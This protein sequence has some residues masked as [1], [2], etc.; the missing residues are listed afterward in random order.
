VLYILLWAAI[1]DANGGDGGGGEG[2]GD[3]GLFTGKFLLNI[4]TCTPGTFFP[5]YTVPQGFCQKLSYPLLDFLFFLKFVNSRKGRKQISYN[6][7]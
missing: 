2:E 6:N 1:I 7:K 4:K 5:K 3:M